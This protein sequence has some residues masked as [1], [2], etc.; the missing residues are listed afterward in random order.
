MSARMQ[1]IRV[2][3]I[4][5]PLL[6]MLAV[7]YFT[8]K[9]TGGFGLKAMGSDVYGGRKYV[10]LMVGILSYFALTARPI[11]PEKARRYIGLFLLGSVLCF[12]S[13]LYSIMPSPLRSI[14]LFIPPSVLPDA[15]DWGLGSTRMGGF[16]STGSA[17]VMWMMARHGVRG[18]LLSGRLLR[19]VIFTVCFGVIFL[20]GYR[21]AIIFPVLVFG[22]LFFAEGMHRSRLMPAFVLSAILASALVVPMARHLPFTFQRSLA[23]LPLDIDPQA[24]MDAE[25]S[26]Q[27][28]LQIWQALLPQIPQYLLLGKGFSFTSETYGEL[29]SGQSG[30]KTVDAAENPLALSS[31]F[32]SGPLS[33]ILSFGIW[34]AIVWLWFWGACFWALRRNYKYGDPALRNSNSFLLAYFAVKCVSFMVIFGAVQNDIGIFAGLAGLSVALNNG[35][36][37]PVPQPVPVRQPAPVRRTW[38]G[39][40]PAFQR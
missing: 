23:F 22:V 4:T 11:P 24:R 16:S 2:P 5:W 35:V 34:G 6:A 18:I 33:V 38:P 17:I 13:D 9:M 28:R 15:G 29:M 30:F 8:A 7:V 14:Y 21:S 32:H 26:T 10:T 31:D 40:H 39:P 3:Q 12:I 1:F 37:K 19:L 27:W 36:R 25:G 20:G